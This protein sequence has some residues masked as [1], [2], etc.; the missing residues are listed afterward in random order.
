MTSTERRI[1]TMVELPASVNR[2]VR[3]Y[4]ALN[5]MTKAEA[6]AAIIAERFGDV[7]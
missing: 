7:A 3:A 5:E 4:G 2:A 1:K 6:I